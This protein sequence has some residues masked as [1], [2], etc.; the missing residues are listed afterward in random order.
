MEKRL[1]VLLIVLILSSSFAL[2]FDFHSVVEWVKHLIS[3]FRPGGVSLES[4][5]T[6]S[7]TSTTLEDLDVSK[8]LIANKTIAMLTVEECLSVL[9]GGWSWSPSD[10]VF[11]GPRHPQA[12]DG[13]YFSEITLEL[14][15]G[16]SVQAAVDAVE[17]YGLEGGD[18]LECVPS[19]LISGGFECVSPAECVSSYD[20]ESFYIIYNVN[21]IVVVV[22]LYEFYECES[23]EDPHVKSIRWEERMRGFAK[24]LSLAQK[25]KIF[26]EII[27]G[28]SSPNIPSNLIRDAGPVVTTTSTLKA[29]TTTLNLCGDGILNQDEVAVD[30]GG[31]CSARCSVL[32]LKLDEE[33]IWRNF[34]FEYERMRGTNQGDSHEI[35]I[36]N[37]QGLYVKD[38]LLPGDTRQMDEVRYSVLSF[39]E[40]VVMLKVSVDQELLDNIPSGWSFLMVGGA[41]CQEGGSFCER[42]F[43][44]YTIS[45]VDRYEQRYYLTLP[46]NSYA[47]VKLSKDS[48]ETPDRKLFLR[49]GKE[50]V[51]GGYSIIYYGWRWA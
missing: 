31:A 16:A 44:G 36:R 37:P 38:A 23:L 27:L 49:T 51:P 50:Y 12:G 35:I 43:N 5:T 11:D 18:E 41:N 29:T 21:N 39:E 40:D 25:N 28:E 22:Q 6:L 4:T 34:R 32:E 45:L 7:T 15:L 13:V 17:K 1:T 3:F 46:D 24:A 14:Y 33:K 9:G 8:I 2:A 20:G 26:Y 47:R 42:R 10:G 19:E 48:T 30:C